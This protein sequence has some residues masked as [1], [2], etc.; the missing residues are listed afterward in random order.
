MTEHI[1]KLTTEQLYEIYSAMWQQFVAQHNE[2]TANPH[3]MSEAVLKRVRL[4]RTATGQVCDMIEAMQPDFVTSQERYLV[5]RAQAKIE[6]DHGV[7]F[8]ATRHGSSFVMV[9][10]FP[11]AHLPFDLSKIS[12][13][14]VVI[15]ASFSSRPSNDVLE[16]VELAAGL[17]GKEIAMLTDDQLQ[18]FQL[19]R[20]IGRKYGVE[21]SV[22]V[23]DGSDVVQAEI[24]A[25]S[26]DEQEQIY[27]RLRTKIVVRT[28]VAT[29]TVNTESKVKDNI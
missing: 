13:D 18:R 25:A 28:W 2:A 27:R 23:L 11:G 3:G 7:I 1:L 14:T 29:D 10:E 12:P 22:E 26:P 21:V 24:A 19:L 5:A 20:K 9:P 8:A 15:P 4:C 16:V 17:N 6:A